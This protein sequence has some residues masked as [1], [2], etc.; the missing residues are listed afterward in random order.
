MRSF[1]V[2]IIMKKKKHSE[3]TGLFSFLVNIKKCK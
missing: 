2:E 3:L 1:S